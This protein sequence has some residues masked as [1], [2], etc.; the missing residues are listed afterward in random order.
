MGGDRDM[1]AFLQR[2]AG[3]SLTGDTSEH[4]LLFPY[5]SGANG[6]ST[7]L[8]TL[9]RIWGDYVRRIP[10]VSLL[11]SHGERHPTD[12]AGLRGERFVVGSELPRGK[13]WDESAIKDLTGGDVVTA[14][15]MRQ[16]FFDFRPQ[17]TLWIAGNTLSSFKGVDEALRRRVVLVPFNV[18]IPAERRDPDLPAKLAAEAGQVLAWAIEGAVEWQTKGLAVPASAADASRDYLDG[19]DTLGQFLSD[20]TVVEA[21][22]FVTTTA[23][24]ERF[25]Q[26]SETQGLQS[27]TLRTLQKEVAARGF[28]AARRGAGNGFLGLRLP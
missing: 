13:S 14:R 19:E 3:Y 16:D 17:F 7:C 15:F 6:K 12:L 21:L 4:R 28:I 8:E 27:W 25:R 2:A 10:A 24:H 26:W 9:F 23:L 1:V 22:A 11:N 18:T 20:E 5:G